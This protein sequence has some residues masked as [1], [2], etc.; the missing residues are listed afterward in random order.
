MAGT[1]RIPESFFRTDATTLAR[2][3][4]GQRLV[5][6]IGG[7]RTSGLIVETEAYLGTEDRAAHTFGGRRT[8]ANESMWGAGGRAYVYLIYGMHHCM[9]IVAGSPG[10][11]TAVLVRALQPE[12]GRE[13][14]L[15]RRG[16][17]RRVSELC[18]GPGRLC[19]ALGITRDQ[20]GEDLS[21]GRLLYLERTRT[22]ALPRRTIAVGARIGIDYAREWR[23][24]PL[25]FAVRECAYVSRPA[26]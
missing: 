16:K 2:R 5:S 12:D 14:M 24:A 25:R 23:D 18:A 22:R 15:A 17:A 21:T 20:D 1:K 4:L 3:L 13:V 9:N 6:R 8:A 10:D 19:Q 11:P 7:R 26:P